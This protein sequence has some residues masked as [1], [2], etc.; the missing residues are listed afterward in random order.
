MKITIDCS[1]I[2]EPQHPHLSGLVSALFTAHHLSALENNNVSS[3]A[4]RNCNAGNPGTLNGIASAILSLG[5]SHAPITDAREVWR[6]DDVWLINAVQAG[7]C[8]PGFGNSFFKAGDPKW[9]PVA[10]FLKSHFAAEHWRLMAKTGIML[11]RAPSLFPNAAM[12][13]A[14]A[15]DLLRVP[16][17]QEGLLVLLAR[18]PAWFEL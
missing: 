4:V 8:I 9:E 17:G 18:L 15:C 3:V 2:P 14:I 7:V 1:N 16:D 13:T 10:L 12:Y 11:A 6:R 5:S